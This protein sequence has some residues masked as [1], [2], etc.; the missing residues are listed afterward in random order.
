MDI[1]PDKAKSEVHFVAGKAPEVVLHFNQG[2]YDELSPEDKRK[3]INTVKTFFSEL[4]SKL[5]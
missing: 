2:L 1:E 3:M 4:E 5:T